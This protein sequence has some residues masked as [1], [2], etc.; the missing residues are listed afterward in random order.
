MLADPNAELAKALGITLEGV[1]FLGARPSFSR[2]LSEGGG[3]P[4]VFASGPQAM[5]ITNCCA[6]CQHG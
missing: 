2:V 5:R 6:C 1:P 4:A 3:M